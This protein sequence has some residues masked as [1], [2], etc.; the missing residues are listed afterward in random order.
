M[1]RKDKK[2]FGYWGVWLSEDQSRD[3]GFQVG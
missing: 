1:M 2:I 3:T